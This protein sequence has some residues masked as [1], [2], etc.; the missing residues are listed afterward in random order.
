MG[1]VRKLVALWIVVAASLA[2]AATPWE[3]A[4]V[5][6]GGDLPAEYQGDIDRNIAELDRLELGPRLRL[7]IH[8]E[9]PDR[10]VSFY[11]NEP[12]PAV[13]AARDPLFF[14]VGLKNVP[15]MGQLVSTAR[16]ATDPTLLKDPK[17]LGAFLARAFVGRDAKRLLVVYGHGEGY[18]GLRSVALKELRASLEQAIPRR[19]GKPVDLLWLNS[20]FMAAAEAVYELRGVAHR[21]LASEDAEFS[22]GAP[23]NTI[24]D[25]LEGGP[26]DIDPVAQGLAEA[27]LTSYS[28]LEEGSHSAAVYKSSATIA[29]I[30]PDKLED[31]AKALGRVATAMKTAA[32]G[33]RPRL[34]RRI[35]NLKMAREDLVD[36]GATLLAMKDLGFVPGDGDRAVRE[37]I[38]GLE[39][40]RRGK[41]KT[42]P[43]ALVRAPKEDSLLVFG[44][45]G[46]KRGHEGDE[47]VLGKLPANLAPRAFV[48]GPADKKWPSRPVHKQLYLTPFSVGLNRFDF[49]FA[50]PETLKPVGPRLSFNRDSDLVTFEAEDDD[51]PLVFT[52]YT[53]GIGK[54]AERYTGL[55]VLNPL[56]GVPSLD[57]VETDFY[58]ATHWGDF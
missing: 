3:V 56:S 51:N 18:Q 11:P 14:K 39:V 47:D 19:A 43:R 49:F 48:A 37:A 41:L 50:S 22:A 26:D 30:D 6:V 40:G 58:K 31:L 57:Y 54:T 8:R 1:S 28:V 53:Q 29:V 5:F 17:A 7:S 21:I 35:P 52:G 38:R 33:W 45:D 46:W 42:N 4:V 15:V 44:Y 27:Y 24:G 55:S 16:A 25:E 10:A 32:E 23:F 34:T 13:P 12:T 2:G 36:V 9:L 20:C